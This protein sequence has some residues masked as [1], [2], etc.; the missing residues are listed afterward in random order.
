MSEKSF[1]MNTGN[2]DA[3]KARLELRR[4]GAAG[5]HMRSKNRSGSQRDAIK[6]SLEAEGEHFDD[7]A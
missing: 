3:T 6:Y 1:Y 2:R 7:L 5:V 4:S